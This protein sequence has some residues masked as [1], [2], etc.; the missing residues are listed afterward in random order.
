[1]RKLLKGITPGVILVTLSGVGILLYGLLQLIRT[2]AGWIE[3]GLT[4]AIIGGTPDQIL[5]TDPKLFD[6]ITH[7]QVASSGLLMAFG[8]LVV[9]VAWFALRKGQKWAV[10][11]VL[12]GHLIAYAVALPLHFAYGFDTLGHLGPVYID[13]AFALIGSFLSYRTLYG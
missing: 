4:P 1:M 12:G 8:F 9:C 10:W 7:M 2:F 3:F 13:I 6:Y 5:A 11:T